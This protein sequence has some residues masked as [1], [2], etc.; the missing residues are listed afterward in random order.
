M[1]NDADYNSP[2]TNPYAKYQRRAR[3]L[4]AK[5]GKIISTTAVRTAEWVRLKCLFGCGGYGQ[6]LTCPPRSPTPE[7]TRKLL[8][9]YRRAL[10]VRGDEY[11]DIQK[12]MASLEREAFLDGYWKALALGSGPC[13][14][15]RTCREPCRHPEKAR[16]AMEACGIDVFATV[17]AQG[18]PLKVLCSRKEKGNY[19]G[20][21]LL[22]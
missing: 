6:A 9:E 19:Y 20:L 16:P 12:V 17:R 3:E 5:G 11:T 10:L 13:E 1:G 4:G 7:Q 22:E 14:L 21:L 8:R 15:C 18:L 2:V